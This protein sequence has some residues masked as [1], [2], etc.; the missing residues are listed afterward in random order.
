MA[1]SVSRLPSL[2]SE[3]VDDVD[4]VAVADAVV[5][6]VVVVVDGIL[7]LL[8]LLLLLLSASLSSD[9]SS[10]IGRVISACPRMGAALRGAL[11]VGRLKP[12][13]LSSID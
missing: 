8:L 5:A 7:L 1:L 3:T 4:D 10:V 13:I 6:V 12:G 2:P 11:M 9:P